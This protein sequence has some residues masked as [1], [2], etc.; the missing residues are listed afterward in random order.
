M[1]NINCYLFENNLYY[2]NMYHEY[3][4]IYNYIKNDDNYILNVIKND[5]NNKIT[6]NILEFLKVIEK[7]LYKF[8]QYNIENN[9]MYL[10]NFY[11]I[12]LTPIYGPSNTNKF[13]LKL[14][15]VLTHFIINNLYFIKSLYTINKRDII[16]NYKGPTSYLP[17][18]EY[19]IKIERI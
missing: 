18:N 3:D 19:I 13:I 15:K 17:S 14:N 10:V 16:F 12:S 5:T 9:T 6:K 4:I 8:T 1:T 2:I 11:N 7:K